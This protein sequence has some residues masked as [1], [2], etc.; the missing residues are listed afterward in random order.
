MWFV[1]LEVFPR[2]QIISNAVAFNNCSLT[3]TFDQTYDIRELIKYKNKQ[4]KIFNCET[5]GPVTNETLIITIQVHDRISYLAHLIQSLR[6]AKDISKVLLITSHDL[7][8]E[9]INQMIESIDFCMVMQIFFPFSIQTHPLMFP[10]EDPKDCPRNIT[11]KL[12]ERDQCKN[13]QYPDM[14]GHYREARFTQIKH[15][16]WW[17][18]NRVFDQLEATKNNNGYVL[19]LEE[20]YYLAPDFISTFNLMRSKTIKEC[21]K[22]NIFSL[23]GY[24]EKID[25]RNFDQLDFL[26][27][28]SFR[29]NMGMLINRTTWNEI[30]KCTNYFCDYDDYNYDWSLQ[31]V[32]LNC[33]Q[34]HLF[35]SIIRGPRVFHLGECGV[36]HV[37][38]DCNPDDKLK[39]VLELLRVAK[40]KNFI[41]PSKLN[42]GRES[43]FQSTDSLNPNGGWG[44]LRDR[45]LCHQIMEGLNDLCDNEINKKIIWLK[46]FL[47]IMKFSSREFFFSFK[48]Y[49]PLKFFHFPN[50]YANSII[51][52]LNWFKRRVGAF[53]QSAFLWFFF[54]TKSIEQSTESRSIRN[55]FKSKRNDCEHLFANSIQSKRN[56]QDHLSV[57]HVQNVHKS[58]PCF[59]SSHSSASSMNLFTA[60]ELTTTSFAFSRVKRDMFALQHHKNLSIYSEKT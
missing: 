29:H 59:P 33:L 37:K 32:N 44:D 19:I 58:K 22:C 46:R 42:K 10:G 18:L 8:N 15:H 25:N 1:L 27:W 14:Y 2:N 48:N 39:D 4:Q 17:K 55:Q 36:H 45:K 21:P 53:K 47:K 28:I 5:F 41:F 26:P 20:D 49:F 40:N 43:F 6:E 51:R 30:K 16:V 50:F 52:V 56:F 54:Q 12:A 31:N 35:V 3:P 57:C 24:T 9:T 60:D 11:R 34:N 38:K 7:Y 23:G 13:Y